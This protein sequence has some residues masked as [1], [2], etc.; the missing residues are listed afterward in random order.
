MNFAEGIF[1]KNYYKS[2]FFFVKK[3]KNKGFSLLLE[4]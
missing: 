1:K 2:F 3:R 4:A